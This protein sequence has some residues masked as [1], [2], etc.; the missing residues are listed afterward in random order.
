MAEIELGW[1]L[2]VVAEKEVE[3]VGNKSVARTVGDQSVADTAPVVVI[4]V[5]E[6]SGRS[7]LD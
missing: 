5:A 3:G 4:L 1:E 6:G 7:M 2:G